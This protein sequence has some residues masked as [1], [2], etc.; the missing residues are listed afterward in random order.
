[1]SS[2]RLTQF[3]LVALLSAL[4]L[5]GA[6]RCRNMAYQDRNQVDYGPLLVRQVRGKAIDPSG[7]PVPG[8]CVGLFK[9]SDHSLV[10]STATSANGEFTLKNAPR[11]EYRLVAQYPAFGTANARVRIGRGAKGVV[12]RMRPSGI[13]TTSYIESK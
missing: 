13:D 2:G 6:E 3:L 8:V 1:M 9:E 12:L 5:P 4:S 7:V 10:T 11:G